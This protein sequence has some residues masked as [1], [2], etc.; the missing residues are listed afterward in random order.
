VRKAFDAMLKDYNDLEKY[1]D[2]NNETS[3]PHYPAGMGRES[4]RLHREYNALVERQLNGEEHL[5]AD[6]AIITD[7]CA[8]KSIIL[9]PG[10][11]NL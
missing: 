3:A 11:E 5:G 4:R 9:V 7:E 10:G 8:A 2:E 6:I 1:Y